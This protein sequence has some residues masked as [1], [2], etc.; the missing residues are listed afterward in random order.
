MT[1][2]LTPLTPSALKACGITILTVAELRLVHIS[3]AVALQVLG[4]LHQIPLVITG[5]L[6]FQDSVRTSEMQAYCQIVPKIEDSTASLYCSKNLTAR[7][8][9]SPWTHTHTST[10]KPMHMYGPVR[11]SLLESGVPCL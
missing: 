2:Q 1:H 11:S 10:R 5:I 8:C 3:S 7:I 4:T 6:F 9:D